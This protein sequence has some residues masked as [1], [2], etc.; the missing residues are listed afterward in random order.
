MNE[1]QEKLLGI[2][3]WFHAF[4]EKE[5][6]TYYISYGTALGA[7]RH[8]G[9][10]PWDDDIDVCMPRADYERCKDVFTS[11]KNQIGKYLLETPYMDASDYL[12]TFNKLYDTQTVLIEK[13]RNNCKRGIYLDI[14]PLD[15]AGDTIDDAYNYHRGI[16]RNH[17]LLMTRVCAIRKQ[18]SIYK[19]FAIL[20]ARLI[21]NAFFDEKEWTRKIDQMARQRDYTECQYVCNYMGPYRVKEII[22]KRMSGKP[23]I[24]EVEGI[25]L[26]GPEHYEEYLAHLYGDWRKLPP[27]E[28]RGI[29]HDFLYLNLE[30]S[31][32]D[33]DL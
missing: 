22:E 13:S 1:L 3:R 15:G 30:Q 33:C 18:R 25:Q 4:C 19:N 24:Y 5:N 11:N 14:F 2:L 32:L 20:A 6:L 23:T 26:Y 16:D 31:Y 7:V 9:F 27:V 12:Y 29:Q 17:M 10:I 28:K 8:R 21:P